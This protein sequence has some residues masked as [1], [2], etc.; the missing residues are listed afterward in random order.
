MINFSAAE[1]LFN[2]IDL[3]KTIEGGSITPSLQT[4]EYIDILDNFSYYEAIA[5]GKGVINFYEWNS[6]ISLSDVTDLTDWGKL[7]IVMPKMHITI[8]KAKLVMDLD[9]FTFGT[10]KQKSFK[11]KFVFRKDNTGKVIEFSD[12]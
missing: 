11:V 8:W 7:E 10:F 12:I 9:D 1:I 5:G 3:G 2:G 6:T 4:I